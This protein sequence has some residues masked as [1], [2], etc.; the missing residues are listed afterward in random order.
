MPNGYGDMKE[1]S[2]KYT[3][4]LNLYCKTKIEANKKKVEDAM[5]NAGFKKAIITGTIFEQNGL[6]NTALQFKI[7]LVNQD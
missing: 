7:A 1:M 6:Y 5:I 3:I 4:L 2:T